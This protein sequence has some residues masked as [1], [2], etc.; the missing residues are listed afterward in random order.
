M[1]NVLANSLKTLINKVQV[2][3]ASNQL[4]VTAFIVGIVLAN[5]NKNLLLG[6][7]LGGLTGTYMYIQQTY[8]YTLYLLTII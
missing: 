6:Y 4:M 3:S 5:S 7:L 8:P 1:K 2:S